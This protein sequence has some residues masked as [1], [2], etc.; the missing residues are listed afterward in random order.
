MIDV[1]TFLG[2]ASRIEAAVA[3]LNQAEAMGVS[4]SELLLTRAKLQLQAGQSGAAQATISQAHAVGIR[5][6]R[7]ALLDAQL[8]IDTMG[9]AGADQA[10]AILAAAAAQD[11]LDL[12]VQRMRLDLI[13]TFQKWTAV[14][15]ALADFKEALYRGQGSAAEAHLTSARIYARLSRWTNALSEYRIALAD[16]GGDVAL[17]MEYGRA[18]DSAGRNATAR[19]AYAQAARLSPNNPDVLNALKTIDDRAV[20][21]R[22]Q[23]SVR[24]LEPR[25]Q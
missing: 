3:V 17:W 20:R 16:Q 12:K 4:R 21:L 11:P 7:L 10:L 15:R 5:D 19:E 9:P 1:A 6:A 14:D 18:A 13:T 25:P 2:S 24:L 8:R 23:D 22:D